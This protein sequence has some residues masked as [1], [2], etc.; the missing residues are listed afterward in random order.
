LIGQTSQLQRSHSVNEAQKQLPRHCC[1]I[2][3][4]NS[5]R[6]RTRVAKLGRRAPR[7]LLMRPYVGVTG[8]VFTVLAPQLRYFWAASLC[9][10]THSQVSSSTFSI[11]NVWSLLHATNLVDAENKVSII[12]CPESAGAAI[13]AAPTMIVTPSPDAQGL[14]S[15]RSHLRI[16]MQA[17]PR[18]H[19]AR[20][21]RISRKLFLALQLLLSRLV[22]CAKFLAY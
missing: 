20:R 8:S 12:A 9:R 15:P 10:A 22:F 19:N 5:L 7:A 16:S 21:L 2:N 17:R 13:R 18:G 6:G 14:C 4:G 1:N 11:G 3:Y